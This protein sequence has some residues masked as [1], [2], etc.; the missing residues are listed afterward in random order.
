[1]S[2][3]D[4]SLWT[5]ATEISDRPYSVSEITVQVKD[6]LEENLPACWVEG[7][8]SQYTLHSSGHR[9]FTLKDSSS[10]LSAVMFKW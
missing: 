9:Y 5:D 1:M 6:L 4:L 8:I 2:S 10:Q 3:D 7:E